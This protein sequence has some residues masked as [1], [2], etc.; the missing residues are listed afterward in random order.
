[1]RVYCIG[2]GNEVNRPLLEQMATQAGGLAAFVSTE[3]SFK[4]QAQLMRQKLVRPAIENLSVEF[5]GAIIHD[6]E[7]LELGDLF[8]GAPLRMYGRY[9]SGGSVVATLTGQVQG[10]AWKQ[11][12]ELELPDRDLGN[13]EVERMWAQKRVERL[14]GEERAGQG[15]RAA[16]IVQLSEGYSIVSPYASMLV[17]ENNEEYQRWK[18]EQRNVLRI[19]RDRKS[20]EAT[21]EKLALIRQRVSDDYSVDQLVSTKAAPQPTPEIQPPTGAQ[22]ASTPSPAETGS[23]Q[24]S[25]GVDLNFD[26]SRDSGGG[27]GGGGG[28]IEPFTAVLTIG[29]V[30]AAALGRRRKRKVAG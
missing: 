27:G 8:Y 1:V 14:L 4:R 17:L 7:P 22:P 29:S 11:T 15:A 21:Q 28:A 20:R 24:P 19:Q 9:R 25:R 30:G 13:S 23:Q 10:G 26:F 5:D 3:D 18:I 16:E 2:V 12:V 6:V